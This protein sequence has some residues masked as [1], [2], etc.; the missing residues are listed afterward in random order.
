[1]DLHA[2]AGIIPPPVLTTARLVLRPMGDV[3]PA[4]LAAAIDDYDIAKWL[5]KVP[6]PYSVDDAVWFIKENKAGRLQTWA[7]YHADQFIGAIGADH[8]I[9]YWLSRS[10]WGQGFATEAGH[11]VL[12]HVFN[13]RD[14]TEIR[15]SHF[16]ENV[17]S[18]NVLGK[19]GFLDVGGHRRQCKARN[20]EVAGRTMLLTRTRWDALNLG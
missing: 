7:I 19:L 14:V 16:E 11:A 18:K 2:Q 6:H 12:S 8:E 17:A 3:D 4:A 10:S 9:G 13:D 15:S 1:M 5:T 20:A